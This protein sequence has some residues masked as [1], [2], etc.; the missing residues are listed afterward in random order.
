LEKKIQQTLK[1][2]KEDSESEPE[3]ATYWEEKKGT[4]VEI[5][6]P[7]NDVPAG[8]AP[9]PKVQVGS[10]GAALMPGEGDAIAQFVQQNKRIPRRGEIGLTSDEI[11]FFENAGYVMSGNRHK[12]M[13][14][15]RIRKENQV[16]S[17]EDKRQLALAS[18]EEKAK[19]ENKIIADFRDMLS[20][21]M[22]KKK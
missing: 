4:V 19:K 9:L 6:I 7:L 16:I 1:K 20:T 18:F 5:P 3:E 10:Y 2:Q 15:V 17:A 21:K 11:E 8:P 14:A 12:R 13:T 22:Q